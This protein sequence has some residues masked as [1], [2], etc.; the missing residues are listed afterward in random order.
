MQLDDAEL[1]ELVKFIGDLTGKRFV[2]GSP[3]A[4][5]L[6]ASV[7]SRQ[8]VTVAEAY[9]TFLAV[10]TANGLTV[11]PQG[12]LLKIVETQTWRAS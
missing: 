10:L 6:R 5:K 12:S 8:K 4:A 1:G 7:V 3:K 11:V 2:F 9:Q